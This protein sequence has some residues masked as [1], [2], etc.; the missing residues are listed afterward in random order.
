MPPKQKDP[1]AKKG[2]ENVGSSSNRR[3]QVEEHV[4]DGGIQRFQAGK[5]VAGKPHFSYPLLVKEFIANFNRAIEEPGTFKTDHRYITWVCGKWIKFNPAVMENYYGLTTNN[6]EHIPTE[7]DMALVTRFLYRRAD[8]WPIFGPKFLRNQLMKSMDVFYICVCHDI[9]PT[10]HR[11]DIN[12]SWARFLYHIASGHKIDLENYIFHFIVD[13]A[14]QC[15]SGRLL[16]FPCLISAIFLL[17]VVPLLL[18]DEL[19]TP[20]AHITK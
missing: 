11:T 13:L 1:Q 3:R 7:L 9:D 12:E 6:I 18:H 5:K 17:E 20:E 16:M 15:E 19:E 2:K 8:A 14:S 4:D 10:S